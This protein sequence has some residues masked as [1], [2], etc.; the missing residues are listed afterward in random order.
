ME[1][2]KTILLKRVTLV[3]AW[4]LENGSHLIKPKVLAC[5]CGVTRTLDNTKTREGKDGVLSFDP[6]CLSC[7]NKR[8]RNNAR[9]RKGL[10]EFDFDNG[11]VTGLEGL[12][13]DSVV[14]FNEYV[15]IVNSLMCKKSNLAEQVLFAEINRR[16]SIVQAFKVV[17]KSLL[18]RS[19]LTA[20]L[21]SIG[22]MIMNLSDRDLKINLSEKEYSILSIR[23]GWMFYRG[24]IDMGMIKIIK[25][26]S[27]L[28]KFKNHPHMPLIIDK[29]RMDCLLSVIED[30]TLVKPAYLDLQP[31]PIGDFDDI[32]HPLA[33]KLVRRLNPEVK[34]EFDK[35]LMP[36]VWETI[37]KHQ[38]IAYVVNRKALSV[39]NEC[40]D[41]VVITGM[42]GVNLDDA[43]RVA[44]EEERRGLLLAAN[45]YPEQPF[46]QC[47]Y[48]DF[49]GRLYPATSPFNHQGGGIAKSLIKLNVGEPL[50]QSGW[51][52]LL[53]YAATFVEGRASYEEKLYLADEN[54]DRWLEIAENP[55][56]GANKAYWQSFGKESFEFLATILEVKDAVDSGDEY[57]Y[58]S[59]YITY[60]DASV[61][62][63]QILAALS[64]DEEAAKYCNLLPS[65]ER[66]DYY[67]SVGNKIWES[68][69]LKNHKFWGQSKFNNQSV[70]RGL[71]KRSS[72]VIWYSC[73][74][75]QMAN[76]IM[77]D[78]KDDPLFEGITEDD[79]KWL[80]KR[81]YKT[82]KELLSGPADLMGI[83]M[84]AGKTKALDN[85]E[86]LSWVGPYNDFAVRQTYRE[87]EYASVGLHTKQ[88]KEGKEGRL[89]VVAAIGKNKKVVVKDVIKGS[90]ANVVH[91]FDAQIVSKVINECDFDVVT[92]HDAF[93]CLPSRAQEVGRET[94]RCFEEMF[95]GDA[96]RDLLR[97]MDMEH[98]MPETLG[99]LEL[100]G[101]LSLNEYAFSF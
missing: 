45:K 35:L 14:L 21:G 39:F 99:D 89:S 24:F 62:G 27:T 71:C 15:E 95:E 49:R 61:S 29:E 47:M 58:I 52:S 50:G 69:E 83:F 38:R 96:L 4:V 79:C 68:T 81:V 43:S 19:L 46:Y 76:I 100:T 63:L 28:T 51:N 36:K 13:P 44:K 86:D 59:S 41:D 48:M 17:K 64:K 37:N 73:G 87:H 25:D 23:I 34:N 33:K 80:A 78:H 93:G 94:R 40:L 70:I 18:K 9:V 65:T 22:I 54:L 10:S 42:N 66:S 31:E 55:L 30:I 32:Y 6:L 101:K 91:S 20:T 56:E 75:G 2:L 67:L 57:G 60:T 82:C 53:A 85:N 97:S 12:N 26:T 88:T 72:M 90:S 98:L 7:K 74:A 1:H 77:D 16:D 11:K 5:K 84:E 8:A 3:E 92:I